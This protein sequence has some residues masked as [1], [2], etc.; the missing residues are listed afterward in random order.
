MYH[1]SPVSFYQI[2]HLSLSLFVCLL[3]VF[4][5]FASV[6]LLPCNSRVARLNQKL[7]FPVHP[8]PYI[9]SYS[10]KAYPVQQY[11]LVCFSRDL[12]THPDSF[13]CFAPAGRETSHIKH[14]LPEACVSSIGIQAA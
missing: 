6:H 12:A 14:L 13:A 10:I 11:R 3:P 5:W 4:L 1:R 7:V 9:S 2:L 8:Y